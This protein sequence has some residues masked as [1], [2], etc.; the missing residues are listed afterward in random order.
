MKP[1]EYSSA[2]SARS[3]KNFGILW[4]M[5]DQ[6]V[7]GGLIGPARVEAR[8]IGRHRADRRRD[9]HVVVVEDDDQARLQRAG[10]VHRLIGHARRHRA[11][12]DHG[13]NVV[14]AA[15]EVARHGHAEAGGNR[16]R[17]VRGA[18]RVVVAL[19]ALGEAGE[20]AAGAQRADA[21]AAAGEDLVRVGLMADVPDQAI[22]RRVED[23]VDR[24][25]Q[26]DRRRGRRRNGRR[27]P[28]PRRWFPGA[29]RRR[30][31]ASG[32]ASLRRSSGVL[33]VSRSGV[34]LNVV[35]AIFQFCMS[36]RIA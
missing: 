20:A 26:L 12:A 6:R 9:R 32:R 29:A 19:G 16:G 13:D 34:L 31:A 4:A 2:R 15:G 27:S 22:V 11:V 24:R 8:Q 36:E 7:A 3:S 17:G 18:E 1:R 23:I 25:G 21:V 14:V 28:T 33:M 30:P 10:V 35:T 5:L